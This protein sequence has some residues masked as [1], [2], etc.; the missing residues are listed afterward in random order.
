MIRALLLLISHSLIISIPAASAHC[1]M[2]AGYVHSSAVLERKKS[3]DTTKIVAKAAASGR[4]LINKVTKPFRGRVQNIVKVLLDRDSTNTATELKAL[5]AELNAKLKADSVTLTAGT[6]EIRK[7]LLARIKTDS[8]TLQNLTA[9]LQANKNNASQQ[10]ATSNIS[11]ELADAPSMFELGTQPLSPQQLKAKAEKLYQIN[12]LY[13]GP[14]PHTE[15]SSDGKIKKEINVSHKI[16]ILGFYSDKSVNN[17]SDFNFHLLTTLVYAIDPM[18]NNPF[19]RINRNHALFENARQAGCKIVLSATFNKPEYVN[20]MFRRASYSKNFITK[21]LALADSVN[22]AGINIDFTGVDKS[23]N[24]YFVPFINLLYQVC[25]ETHQKLEIS[26]TIPGSGSYGNEMVKA[27]NQSVSYFIIDFTTA[28]KKPGALA[29]LSDGSINSIETRFSSYLDQEIPSSK[30]ILGVPYHGDESNKGVPQYISYNDIRHNYQDAIPVY[31]KGGSAALIDVYAN[32]S[33]IDIWYDN[34]KTLSEKYDYALNNKLKGVA[35]KYIDED[36]TLPELKQEL[37]YKLFKI[38]TVLSKIKPGNPAKHVDSSF[39]HFWTLLIDNPCNMSSEFDPYRGHLCIL[40]WS[41]LGMLVI[42][43]VFF[44][45]KIKKEGDD[46]KWKEKLSW[47]LIIL[48]FLWLIVF[49]MY[50]FFAKWNRFFGP[51][52]GTGDNCV[53]IKFVT[54]FLVL[55]GGIA[56][57]L[58]IWFVYKLNHD[59]D[60]V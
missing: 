8:V 32:S 29:P 50:L 1:I 58:I 40:T 44:R 47:A 26:I 42:G 30:F 41:V 33:Y 53:N 31:K 49:L 19:V 14:L 12:K 20:Q 25:Q 38:D 16:Q 35:I 34:E 37:E 57:G 51:S 23:L 2:K 9:E 24:R 21:S 11:T 59:D 39:S 28:A 3:D 10:P 7:Q 46:W 60:H 27:L 6:I 54:L 45:Y 17:I 52:N 15:I 43:F 18:D 56:S 5:R 36:G 48:F 13:E 22:A 55:L 4:G